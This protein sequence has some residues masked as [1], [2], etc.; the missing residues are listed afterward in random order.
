MLLIK[1]YF[2]GV[3][4]RESKARRREWA[5]R[6]IVLMFLYI[7]CGVTQYMVMVMVAVDDD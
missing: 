5:Q 1:C 2:S 4:T 6:M 7:V 3:A